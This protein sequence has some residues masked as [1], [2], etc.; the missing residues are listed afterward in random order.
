MRISRVLFSFMFVVVTAAC[1]QG[2]VNTAEMHNGA[3]VVFKSDLD[4]GSD[5]WRRSVCRWTR[6]PS[7]GHSCLTCVEDSGHQ[8][9]AIGIEARSHRVDEVHD[10]CV[11]SVPDAR[12][13]KR[14]VL[15]GNRLY[16]DCGATKRLIAGFEDIQYTEGLGRWAHAVLENGEYLA[17][18]GVDGNVIVIS[19][20]AAL[21][22]VEGSRR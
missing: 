2:R 22:V 20:P 4:P 19:A 7:G 14:A 12:A 21:C 5:V 18:R 13:T 15:D 17:V 11:Q 3:I 9:I 10:A 6:T 16:L 8:S 1:G